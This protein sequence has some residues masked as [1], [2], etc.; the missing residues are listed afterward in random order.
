MTMDSLQA[1]TSAKASVI[2]TLANRLMIP[3]LRSPLHGIASHT[4]VLFSFQG[5][6]VGKPTPF[7]P[8]I[9]S[10]TT[11]WRLFRGGIFST[12]PGET[13]SHLVYSS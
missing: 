10:R 12:E 8:D 6:K 3:L 2:F 5:A 9:H 1:T 4:L 13:A 11:R 7:R